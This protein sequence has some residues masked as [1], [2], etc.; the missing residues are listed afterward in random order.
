MKKK[1]V[2]T[3]ALVLMVAASIVAAPIELKGSIKAGYEMTFN[4]NGIKA[5]DATELNVSGLSLTGD[6][7][8]VA[9]GADYLKFGKDDYNKGTLTIYLTK[10][11][12]EQGMD[13]GDL[14]VDLA[15]G[16]MG[17]LS[18]PSV[19]SDPN[20]SVGDNNYK[21]RM[22][23]AYS[24]SVTVGYTDLLSV[25]FGTSPVDSAKTADFALDS[26]VD[27]KKS[28]VVGA[29]V[30]PVTGVKVA[31]AYANYAQNN[32]QKVDKDP[33]A[34]TDMI[35]TYDED[36]S[37]GGSAVVDV[38][39]LAD[40]DFTLT[41]SVA[42]VYFLG[43]KKNNLLAAV[44]AGFGDIDA[45][46]E[47]QM[48]DKTNNLIGKVSYNG[49]ENVGLNAKLTLAD[50]TGTLKTTIGAGASYAMGG[51]TYALDGSYEVDGAFTLKP[52]VKV[53]F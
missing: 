46:A 10:A 3:L 48:F 1:F 14:T 23:G 21:V 24:T 36:G 8:K 12:A 31:V 20:G 30:A 25:Y 52:S 11:L 17:T 51:V 28:V 37:F 38:A 4:P 39:A 40:L 19:Y 49:I 18:G 16:N 45:Y 29:T 26:S 7:W 34:K 44:S 2:L 35:A 15:I 22:A 6:F 42:D 47:Y 33:S 27:G 13:M 9:V 53:S 32:F 43:Q 41:A 5:L 50:L